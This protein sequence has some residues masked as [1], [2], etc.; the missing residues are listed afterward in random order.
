MYTFN[1]YQLSAQATAVYNRDHAVVYPALGLAGESGE[2]AEKVK[3]WLCGDKELDREG[4][5]K[6]LG[7]VLWYLSALAGDL[8]LTLEEVAYANI[9]KLLDRQSKGTIKGD[10]DNR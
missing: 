3:K 6:E 2:V 1:D 7:D 10:G 4:L 5:L 8:G 9:N